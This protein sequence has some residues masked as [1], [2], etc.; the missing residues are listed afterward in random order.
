M[1]AW[2]V[3]TVGCAL[4][5]GACSDDGGGS[6]GNGDAASTDALESAETTDTAESKPA[7]VVVEAADR[8]FEEETVRF[9]GTTHVENADMALDIAVDG[10]ADLVAFE[11][12]T[13][14][15]AT[16]P[17]LGTVVI[18][19]RLVDGV[20]YLD[21]AQQLA[22]LVPAGVPPAPANDDLLGS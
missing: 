8:A 20:V 13:S 6:S 18:G 16:A 22:P 21:L 14:N 11:N 1:R 17:G 5:L 10:V 19:S 4:F 12:S 9:A 7:D 15:T 2:V 3:L